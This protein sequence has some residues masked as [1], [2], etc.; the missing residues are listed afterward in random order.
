M[1]VFFTT[2]GQRSS[3]LLSELLVLIA[4]VEIYT[5]IVRWIFPALSFLIV[6]RAVIT[7][8][9]NR[10]QSRVWAYLSVS[11]NE[12]IPLMHWENSI[13]RSKLSDVVLSLPFISRSHAVLSFFEG[14]WRISD[15]GSK[16]GV[17][18]NGQR[19]NKA[20]SLQFGDVISLAGAEFVL[21]PSD[22]GTEPDYVE[23]SF[24]GAWYERIVG[25]FLQ[26]QT[27]SSSRTFFLILLFQI[28]GGLQ[29]F[30]SFETAIESKLLFYYLSFLFVESLYFAFAYRFSKRYLDLLLLAF[31]LCG[32]DLLLVASAAPA[33]LYKQV[34]AIFL[35]LIAFTIL[36]L[37]LKDLK[38][39]QK[40]RNV[41]IG[42]AVLLMVL[43]LL[44]G[45]ARNGAK[46]WIDLGPVT[47]QP[48][49]FVKV[50]FVLA[51]AA[52][53]DR[54]LTTRS[55]TAFIAFS[56]TCV[57]ALILMRD[58][59]TAVIFF[60]AF[61]VVAFMRSGDIRT[62]ALICAGA[63]LGAVA[64]V[65]F[66]PYIAARFAVFRHVWEFE[67]SS[68]Y[69]QTRTMTAA[70]SGGLIGIGGGKG[71]LIHVPA[72]DTDLIFGVICE[73]WGL[74]IALL[75]AGILLFFALY[76]ILMMARCR[77]SFYAISACG[78]AAIYLI[79]ASLNIF[80]SFDLLP[81]TGVTLPFVSVGG[82]SMLVSWALLAVI[83]S[84][85]ERIRPDKEVYEDDEDEED[86]DDVEEKY[87]AKFDEEAF[88]EENGWLR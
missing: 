53:L 2:V 32:L 71:Y 81:L 10:K 56:G 88:F 4:P 65:S 60:G 47:F 84:V 59:G 30:F 50:A 8:I 58:L 64:V 3:E 28:L 73:E 85:D 36:G 51:G 12:R 1:D 83:K 55:L 25:W 70:A 31:F 72:S 18:I 76:P 5:L 63:V 68:G 35:G 23:Q 48:M 24:S 52:T 74:L 15:L 57:G 7:L 67:D 39:A 22:Q 9:S 21:L 16:G 66:R 87:E 29:L 41:L 69:Q 34:I 13:G 77:S 54:L 44:L 43:N 26:G 61:L 45:Q 62:I 27:F 40:F 86:E 75:T 79:Q 38:L 6:F 19:I 20:E 33:L 42:G 14:V 82:S 78:A 46:N 37:I 49:E 11:E 17:G 80:G